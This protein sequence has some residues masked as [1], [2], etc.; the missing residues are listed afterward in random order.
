MKPLIYGYL[1]VTDDLEDHELLQLECGLEKLAEAEGF[2]LTETR[3]ESQPGYYGTFYELSDQ[4]K[5]AQVHH[6]VVPSLGHLSSHPLL[7]EQLIRRLED[8]GVRVW[9]VEP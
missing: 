6:V 4:L 9:V 2:C 3:Y 8:A 5:Q 7:R 1:R